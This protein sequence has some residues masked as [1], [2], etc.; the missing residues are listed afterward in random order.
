MA[1]TDQTSISCKELGGHRRDGRENVITIQRTAETAKKGKGKEEETGPS[2]T[3]VVFPQ[4]L[5][6]AE[7]TVV[8]RDCRRYQGHMDQSFVVFTLRPIPR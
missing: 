4:V 5:Q 7:Y 3:R 6:T 1:F 8:H 2:V